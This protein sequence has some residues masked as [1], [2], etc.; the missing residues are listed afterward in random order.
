MIYK[1]VVRNPM[2]L[3]R[4]APD[5]RERIHRAIVSRAQQ[6]RAGERIEIAIPAL[7]ATA[8]KP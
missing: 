5:A 2:I 3:E 8:V 6:F 7:M 4:Q 1:S